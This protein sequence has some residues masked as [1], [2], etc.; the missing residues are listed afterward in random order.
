MRTEELKMSEENKKSIE[1]KTGLTFDCFV[2]YNGQQ[3]FSRVTQYTAFKF[4]DADNVDLKIWKRHKQHNDCFEPNR[5]TKLGRE[6]AEFLFNG[7]KGSR[8]DKPLN[9]LGLETNGRF[10]FPY[11]EIFGE[12]ILIYLDDNMEPKDENVIEITKKEFNDLSN[13]K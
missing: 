13:N 2:G 7:L 1:E 10:T 12:K 3:N 9:I 6:M 8:F 5:K 4:N 11:V